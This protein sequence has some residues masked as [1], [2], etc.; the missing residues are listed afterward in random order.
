MLT[1][2]ICLAFSVLEQSL[3]ENITDAERLYSDIFG[4][5]NN[6]IGPVY[7]QTLSVQLGVFVLGIDDIDEIS[8][9][10]S[11]IGGIYYSWLDERL[12]WNPIE[13][14]NMTNLIVPSSRIWFPD[15]YCINPAEEMSPLGDSR[16]ISRIM[17]NGAV[18]RKM[19]VKFKTSCE[20][21]MTYF[22]FDIQTCSIDLLAW[23]YGHS[24][25]TMQ[26][27]SRTAH[28][29]FFKADSQWELT[30]TE[31]KTN[32]IGE[33]SRVTALFTVKRKPQYF[34]I[35]IL[36]PIFLLCILNP[37]VFHLPIESGERISYTVTIFLSLAV[38]MTLISDIMPRSSQPVCR[39]SL[40][41][42]AIMTLSTLICIMSIVT[43]VMRRKDDKPV[44]MWVVRVLTILKMKS[45]CCRNKNV[46]GK[47]NRN[48]QH[49]QGQHEL[50]VMELTSMMELRKRRHKH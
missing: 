10:F 4:N 28:L 17:S 44:P 19:G 13:F 3:S 35:N 7:N 20:I 26:H 50:N 37:F 24:E 43:M 32:I 8:G 2:Y 11:I 41:L 15:I 1:V 18:W 27:F 30:G 45:C 40:F 23:G 39:L 31:I 14:G 48:F 33:Q 21:D 9:V 25:I 36:L 5:Y 16:V 29:S 47:D 12:S 22:P 49:W 6:E 46:V 38:F 34:V 42:V